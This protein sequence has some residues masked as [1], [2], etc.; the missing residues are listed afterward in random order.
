MRSN[1]CGREDCLL[2]IH[3][4]IAEGIVTIS[5][6]VTATEGQ[7]G[8]QVCIQLMAGAGD[9]AS[10]DNDLTVLLATVPGKAGMTLILCNVD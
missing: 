3:Y 7:T 2:N 1:Y 8:F 4:L 10:L 9:P 6:P 5:A